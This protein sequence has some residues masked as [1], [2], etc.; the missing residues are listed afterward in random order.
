MTQYSIVKLSNLSPLHIGTGRENYDF[1][2]ADLQSDTLSSALAAVRVQRGKSEGLDLFLG[3]FSIS[4]AF[5]YKKVGDQTLYFLPKAQGRLNVE[6]KGEEEHV[7]RK[8]LKKVA[9][10]EQSLWQRLMAG[11]RLVVDLSQLAGQFLLP[12]GI[13]VGATYMT[14]V[15]QRVTV[16]RDGDDAVP[17][18]FEWRYFDA[19]CGLYCLLDADHACKAEVFDLFAQLGENGIGTDRSV[20]GGRFEVQESHLTLQTP[21]DANAQILLSTYIPTE[22]EAETLNLSA[23]SYSMLIRGGFMAGSQEPHLKHLRKKSIFMFAPGSLFATTRTLHGKVVDLRPSFNDPSLHP[24]YRSGRPFSIPI[25][26]Q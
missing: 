8:R 26:K 16:S 12:E 7:Y 14:Q 9:F 22:D 13:K 21:N 6:V 4:S 2:S 17:F 11:E 10:V 23:S 18:F 3:S 1:S 24:V 15:S 25:I 20:G 5:P 19:D